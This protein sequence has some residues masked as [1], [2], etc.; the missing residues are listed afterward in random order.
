[1]KKTALICFASIIVLSCRKDRVCECGIE[2]PNGV[3]VEETTFYDVTKKQG[4]NNCIGSQTVTKT[5][6]STTY[7][8]KVTC[9]LK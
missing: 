6:T 1:M 4:K 3:V 2:T 9:K 7:G 5:A 8:N